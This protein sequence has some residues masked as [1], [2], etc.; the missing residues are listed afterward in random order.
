MGKAQTGFLQL[1]CPKGH[2]KDGNYI[3]ANVRI[4]L[5]DG[6]FRLHCKV[7]NESYPPTEEQKN[8]L[9]KQLG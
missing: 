3:F 1:K 2:P 8:E 7:C 9:L 6:T 5:E 4:Q